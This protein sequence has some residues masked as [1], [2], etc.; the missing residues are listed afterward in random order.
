MKEKLLALLKTKFSGVQDA[1]LQRVADAKVKSISETASE[2]EIKG[3]VD[4][5]DFQ[6]VIDTYGDIRANEASRTAVINY[7][8][9]HSIKNGKPIEMKTEEKQNQPVPDDAPEWAKALIAQNQQL[10]KK[11]EELESTKKTQSL[12]DRVIT[13]L[14][15]KGVSEDF[16]ETREIFVE[17]EDKFDE[18][19]Q[20][21]FGFHEKEKAKKLNMG[22]PPNALGVNLSEQVIDSA[23]DEWAK[24]SEN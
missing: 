11:F 20:K 24:K 16:F 15:E 6:Q 23:I 7:E 9:K 8:K 1:I 10:S 12:K 17:S 21:Y 18:T 13:T 5:I 19:V 2:D 22:T 14:K 4:G 3:V